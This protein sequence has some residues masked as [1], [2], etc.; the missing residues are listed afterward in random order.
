MYLRVP[1]SNLIR[2]SVVSGPA[3]ECRFV[4]N[5]NGR[6]SAFRP[7]VGLFPPVHLEGGS[8]LPLN[9][10]PPFLEHTDDNNNDSRNRTDYSQQDK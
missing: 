2:K 8:G 7:L 1:R 10:G 4:P 6:H 5:P 3:S 9:R